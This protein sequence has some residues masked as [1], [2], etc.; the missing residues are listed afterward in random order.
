MKRLQCPADLLVIA[1]CAL[2]LG[3]RP[4]QIQFVWFS[5]WQGHDIEI[6]IQFHGGQTAA[7]VA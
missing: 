4:W 5:T 3:D 1:N 2:A 7:P 6:Q